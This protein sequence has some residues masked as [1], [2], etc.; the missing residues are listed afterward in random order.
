MSRSLLRYCVHRANYQGPRCPR[1]KPPS[2]EYLIALSSL[3]DASDDTYDLRLLTIQ[4]VLYGVTV[5]RLRTFSSSPSR[6]YDPGKPVS[7]V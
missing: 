4:A 5:T 1:R 3:A 6:I 2:A 7:S